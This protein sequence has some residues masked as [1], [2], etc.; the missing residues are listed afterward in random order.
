VP[1]VILQ[2][3]PGVEALDAYVRCFEPFVFRDGDRVIKVE[4]LYRERDGRGALL[5]TIVAGRDHVQKFFI[6]L[7]PREGELTV[8][9]E[10]LTD[11]EKTPGVRRA[12]ALVAARIVAATGCG[13]AR[14][15]IDEYLMR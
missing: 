15:N 2:G 4:R 9:L 3:R 6:Q 11:P 1:H 7:A 13:Y 5:E 14:S 10:P 8:R 12:L